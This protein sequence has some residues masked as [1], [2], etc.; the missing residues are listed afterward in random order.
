M[1][2]EVAEARF[3][4]DLERDPGCN[5]ARLAKQHGLS[6]RA[7]I[8]VIEEVAATGARRRGRMRLVVAGTTLVAAGTAIWAACRSPGRAELAPRPARDTTA[9]AIERDLY[10]ALDQ[11]DPARVLEAAGQLSSPDESLRLAALRYL[12]AN[13]GITEYRDSMLDMVDDPSDRVR[14]AAIQLMAGV[15]GATVDDRLLDVLLDAKRPQSERLLA[16]TSLER[17]PITDCPAAARRAVD[18]L[19]DPSAAIREVTL[20]LLRGLTGKTIT[21]GTNDLNALHAAWQQALAS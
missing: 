8:R 17:R 15:P 12:V 18:A 9:V 16:S 1:R 5:S 20:R 11:R 4:R 19:L 3:R 10:T 2:D 6:N 21:V 14:P 13:E 7:A